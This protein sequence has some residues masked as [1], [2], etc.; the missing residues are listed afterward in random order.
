MKEV[1]AAEGSQP[2]Q[3]NEEVLLYQDEVGGLD[4]SVYYQFVDDQLVSGAYILSESYMNENQYIKD[5]DNLQS[6]LTEK[7]GAPIKNEELWSGDLYRDEPRAEWGMALATGDLRMIS[8][9]ENEDTDISLHVAGENFKTNLTIV[10]NGVKYKGL[11]E[12][13]DKAEEDGKL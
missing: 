8:L 1:I 10:Y 9:W 11:V 4:F 13:S 12:K 5:Y 6:S 2:M 3:E 7:Y